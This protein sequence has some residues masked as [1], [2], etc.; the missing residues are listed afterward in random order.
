MNELYILQIIKESLKYSV[1]KIE[2]YQYPPG[3]YQTKKIKLDELYQ[4]QEYTKNKIQQ[5][6][7]NENE[8]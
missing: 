4:A 5:L 3:C 6:K 2:N 1:D 8:D 7:Q